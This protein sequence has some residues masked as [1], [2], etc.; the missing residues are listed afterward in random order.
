MNILFI[1]A[2]P[3]DEAYG[4]AGTIAKLSKHNNVTV[5]SLCQGNRPGNEKVSENRQKSFKESC[6]ILGA[7]PI[8][9][10]YSDCHLEYNNVVKSIEQVIKN[11]NPEIVYTHNISDIHKD[12]RLVAEACLVCCRPKLE[13]NIKELYM[14]EMIASTDWSFGQ[15]EPK[16]IPNV[17]VDVS[18]YIEVKKQSINF[19]SSE[20]YDYPDARSVMSME[21]LAKYR[22]KQVGLEYAESFKLIFSRRN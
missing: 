16:F 1:F 7:T 3:D 18:D 12:H 6:A 4:P 15:I 17:Y 13:S 19:Y 9:L 14:C 22:G 21:I 20:L 11:I 10:N 5:V 2:H 8:I